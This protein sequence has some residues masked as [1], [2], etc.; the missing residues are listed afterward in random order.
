MRDDERRATGDGAIER[1]ENL[2]FRFAIDCGRRIIEQQDRWLQQHRP[3]DGETLALA[4][5]EAV[6]TLAEHGVVALRQLQDE[7]VGGGDARGALDLFACRIG[8]TEG[9]VGRDGVGE[10]KTFL[11]NEPDIPP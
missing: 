11:K 3:R 5:A 10:E 6:A 7:F 4:A 9:D 2:V 1:V 8:M